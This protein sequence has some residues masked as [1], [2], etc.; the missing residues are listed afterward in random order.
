MSRVERRFPYHS[1]KNWDTVILSRSPPQIATKKRENGPIRRSESNLWPIMGSEID[2]RQIRGSEK[3]LEAIILLLQE[4]KS[5]SIKGSPASQHFP[6]NSSDND[7][8]ENERD[9]E[10]HR[11]RDTE[12]EGDIE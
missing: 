1:R 4:G 11:D 5:I 10:R 9:R 3:K 12:T 2:R 6:G 8:R 7:Q